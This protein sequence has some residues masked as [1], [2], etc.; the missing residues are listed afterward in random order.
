MDDGG[1]RGEGG[2]EGGDDE[3]ARL[4]EISEEGDYLNVHDRSEVHAIFRDE[5]QPAD[6]EEIAFGHKE[7]QKSLRSDFLSKILAGFIVQ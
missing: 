3:L 6:S 5:G 2:G 7:C 1:E 4:L